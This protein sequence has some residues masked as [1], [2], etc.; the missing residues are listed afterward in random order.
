MQKN[1]INIHIN[2]R[3]AAQRMVRGMARGILVQTQVFLLGMKIRHMVLQ[4]HFHT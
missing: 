3:E 4:E 2:G 1:R